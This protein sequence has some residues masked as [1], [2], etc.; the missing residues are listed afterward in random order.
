[1][2][3]QLLSNRVEKTPSTEVSADR[4]EYLAL[5]EA[6]PDLGVPAGNSYI[7]ASTTTGTRSWIDPATALP[8]PG[9][10]TQVIFNNSGILAGATGLVYDTATGRV[11]IGVASPTAELELAETWNNAGTTF[12]HIKSNVTDTASNSASLLLDLQVGGTSKF[13]IGKGSGSASVNGNIITLTNT[14]NFNSVIKHMGNESLHFVEYNSNVLFLSGVDFTPSVQIPSNKTFGWSSGTGHTQGDL[15]FYRDAAD[16][17]A[18]RRSTNPQTTRIYN[19]FTDASNY[20]RA[21]LGWSTNVLEI[22]TEAAGTGIRRQIKLNYTTTIDGNSRTNVPALTISNVGAGTGGI[23]LGALNIGHAQDQ[24]RITGFDVPNK[25]LSY[26]VRGSAISGQGAHRFSGD[27]NTGTTV[28][29]TGS[30]VDILA[31]STATN[32]FQCRQSD[33]TVMLNVGYS[34]AITIA[35]TVAQ[36]T[37]ATTLATTTKTQVASFPVASFRS[38]KLIIQ[39]Y[40][41]ISGEVQISELLVAHN[42]TTASSTEYG[43]VHTGSSAIVLYDVDISA[44][45]VRLMATRTSANSTQYKISETLI[46]A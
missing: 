32:I 39:A 20:E 8:A 26:S 18:Q 9:S 12:T 28:G 45:N 40:D 10:S 36:S 5:A 19:T 23:A 15:V 41:S 13:K 22:G 37:E 1:M 6:E 34:G 27:A 33:G 2:L 43:V 16:T 14:G 7:L 25:A 4:Y 17:L 31:P 11:G 44:G 38:G 29:A 21:T 35:N 30:I 24:S 3:N 42:G 46:V